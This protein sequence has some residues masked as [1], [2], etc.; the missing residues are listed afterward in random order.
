MMLSVYDN[1][2]N[3]KEVADLFNYSES[4]VRIWANEFVGYLS[5]DAQGAGRSRHYT[6]EDLGVFALVAQMKRAGYTYEDIHASLVAG[7][8]ADPPSLDLPANISAR[9]MTELNHLRTKVDALQR[10]EEENTALKIQIAQLQTEV[11]LLAERVVQVNEEAA[12]RIARAAEEASE[13]IARASEE[14]RKLGLV[15]GELA[16]LKRQVENKS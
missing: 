7:Q 11:R 6:Q 9:F 12:E 16:A 3:T 2:M 5:T 13:R 8:R 10:T 15:E 4:A 14:G 1:V